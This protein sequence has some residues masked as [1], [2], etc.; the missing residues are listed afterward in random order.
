M[1]K[2]LYVVIFKYLPVSILE[3]I[4]YSEVN[5]TNEFTFK[6]FKK[7][8]DTACKHF[9]NSNQL[10]VSVNKKK[11]HLVFDSFDYAGFANYID[12]KINIISLENGK[13]IMKF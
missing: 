4:G 1:N 3:T 7:I 9:L 8:M 13:M 12:K 2:I 11:Y 5:T 10:T 6:E